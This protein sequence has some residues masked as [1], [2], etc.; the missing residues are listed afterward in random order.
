M[1]ASWFEPSVWYGICFP[2]KLIGGIR[3]AIGE[4]SLKLTDGV[5]LILIE[6]STHDRTCGEESSEALDRCVGLLGFYVEE[7][8]SLEDL[9]R[10]DASLRNFMTT[11]QDSL[12]ICEKRTPAILAGSDADLDH[13][14]EECPSELGDDGEFFDEDEEDD[15]DDYES[16][17][18]NE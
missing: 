16:S 2:V 5:E 8:A 10:M 7:E 18:A 4:K 14:L 12:A 15:E 13:F 11:N 6:K 3:R 9:N 1:G 17:E